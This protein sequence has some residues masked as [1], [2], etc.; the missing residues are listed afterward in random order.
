MV[1][2][3]RRILVPIPE[4]TLRAAIPAVHLKRGGFPGR[5]QIRVE[6]NASDGLREGWILLDGQKEA[7]VAWEGS[8]AGT[9]RAPLEEGEHDLMTKVETLSG[10]SIIDMRRLTA[11]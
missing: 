2:A 6:A 3:V 11:N 9:L 7:Y 4:T 5:P 8:K 10:V 1:L